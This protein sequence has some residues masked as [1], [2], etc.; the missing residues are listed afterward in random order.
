MRTLIKGYTFTAGTR[1]ID[2]SNANTFD[3]ENIRLIVNETQKVVICSSMQKDLIVSIIDGV[4]TYS[5][6]LPALAEDDKLT[7]EID[8]GEN[9]PNSIAVLS[10]IVEAKKGISSAIILKGGTASEVASFVELADNIND[11]PN[12][13][14]YGTTWQ[15][16]YEPTS[17][18]EVINNKRLYLTEINNTIAQT[19]DNYAFQYCSNLTTV[20]LP[21]AQTIGGSA[22]GYCSN[23]TTLSLPMAQTIQQYAFISCSNLTTVSLPAAQTIGVY[24]FN[25]CSNLTTITFGKLT[26]FGSTN[27]FL[28]CY[29][30][31]N[32]II[33][34]DTNI[35]LDFSSLSHATWN[36]NID[37]SVW[38]ENFVSGIINNLFDFT[39]GAA[40][41]IKL[42]AYPYAKLTPETIALAAAKNWN[43]TS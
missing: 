43:I 3:I 39:S 6:T 15:T 17:A 31:S 24:A 2:C 16:G 13:N 9:Y 21:A 42:G 20:S 4:I 12:F 28:K 35:N 30:L 5:D 1:S 11:I 37:A 27:T 22:F 26:S 41:T 34:A 32:I 33:G 25:S 8:K 19:I 14:A 23:L 40:H 10:E 38:N 18:I 36:N 7:I 29:M